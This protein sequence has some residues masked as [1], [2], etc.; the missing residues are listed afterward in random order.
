M[1]EH[2]TSLLIVP[3]MVGTGG[4]CKDR[5]TRFPPRGASTNRANFSDFRPRSLANFRSSAQAGDMNYT[6]YSEEDRNPWD[7][8]PGEPSNAFY[9]FECYL[10]MPYWARKDLHA[11][12]TYVGNPDASHVSAAWLSYKEE[13]FWEERVRAY[14][15]YVQ[16]VRREQTI[17]AQVQAGYELGDEQA[18]MEQ[19]MFHVNELCYEKA[20]EKLEEEDSSNWRPM[21]TINLVRVMS[22]GYSAMKK[23]C[24]SEKRDPLEESEGLT[25]EEM[26]QLLGEKKSSNQRRAEEEARRALP[27]DSDGEGNNGP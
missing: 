2:T 4:F 26:K 3:L 7:R 9:A 5:D 22:E 17:Q 16:K 20:R 13:F 21:D 24:S 18:R 11:Y 8:I 12:R 10:D 27:P 1:P 25:D 23:A 6:Y 14:D 15:F 19:R